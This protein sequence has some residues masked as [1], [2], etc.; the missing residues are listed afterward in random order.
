MM[1]K[2]ERVIEARLQQYRTVSHIQFS[3]T[4]SLDL[5]N[6]EWIDL[7]SKYYQLIGFSS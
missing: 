3:W 1:Q 4:Q 7:H 2:L 6:H 5:E